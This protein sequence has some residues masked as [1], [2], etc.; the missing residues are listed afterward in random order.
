MSAAEPSAWRFH[1]ARLSHVTGHVSWWVFVVARLMSDLGLMVGGMPRRYAD[2]TADSIFGS[3]LGQTDYGWTAYVPL[4]DQPTSPPTDYFSTANI[5]ATV[6]VVAVAVTVIAAV[7]EAIAAGR[8]PAGVLTI[9]APIA[10]AA[11]VLTALYARTGLAGDLQLNL[12][13]VFVLVLL[14]V[15]VREVWSRVWAPRLL[16]HA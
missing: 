1:T 14:G 12:V 3:G 2:Y 8:W 13:T 10:G 5:I 11:I 7:A 9:L 16:P 6:T 4:T 15:M